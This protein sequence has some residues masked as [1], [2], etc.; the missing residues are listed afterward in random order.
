MPHVEAYESGAFYKRE[1]P[2][3]MALVCEHDLKPGIFII[4]GYVDLPDGGPGLGR[5]LHNTLEAR[6][7]IIGVAKTPLRGSSPNIEVLR[8]QSH[9]PLYVTAAGMD[10]ESACTNI[11]AMA[12]PNRMPDILKAVDRATKH[13]P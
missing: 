3:L 1:L 4:D 12:G 6:A 5:H 7:P 13:W 11:Q 10:P 2:C 9:T 8:G